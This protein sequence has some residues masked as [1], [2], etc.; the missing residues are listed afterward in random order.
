M[1]TKK[2]TSMQ[3]TAVVGRYRSPFECVLEY[4]INITN[5]T[6]CATKRHKL[7]YL[8]RGESDAC[9]FFF[10]SLFTFLVAV[11]VSS[12]VDNPGEAA[13]DRLETGPSALLEVGRR[14]TFSLFPP[15]MSMMS[16]SAD[17]TPIFL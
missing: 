13:L 9:I 17:C 1:I 14:V 16:S 6:S 11:V 4:L 10:R 3:N 5:P 8:T 15:S 12:D 7:P 2:L